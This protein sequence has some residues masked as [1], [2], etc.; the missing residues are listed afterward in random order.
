MAMFRGDMVRLIH[1][2]SLLLS[3][4]VH[5]ESAAITLMSTDVDII[6]DNIL[7]VHEI[8]AQAIEVMIGFW[9]LSR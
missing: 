9:L 6:C 3:D 7:T 8:W 2:Q 4:G 1:S 5:D